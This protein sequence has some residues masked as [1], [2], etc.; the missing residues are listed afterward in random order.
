MKDW[1]YITIFV[2]VVVVVGGLILFN[3]ST[4]DDVQ[5]DVV[6]ITSNEPREAEED[7]TQQEI[8]VLNDTDFEQDL[9]DEEMQDDLSDLDQIDDL[10]EDMD[11]A[12]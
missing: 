3:A 8:D 7:P 4:V 12:L 2:L 1:R 6:E 5:D 10:V 9:F 11:V